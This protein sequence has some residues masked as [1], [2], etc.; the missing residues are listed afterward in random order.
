M[1]VD[2]DGNVFVAM[3]RQGRIL[4]F[5]PYGIPIGQILLPGRE[6][7]HFL[8]CTSLALAPGSRDLFIVARDEV[9][10]G[11]TMI[12]KAQGMTSGLALYSHH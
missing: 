8:R 1:R 5:S 11:G 2:V 10:G 12:F 3:N 7:N 4:V 9:G 6:R